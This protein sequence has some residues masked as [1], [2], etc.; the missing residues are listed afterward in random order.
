M[1]L[2]AVVAD[3]GRITR[4][5][6]EQCTSQEQFERFMQG[7]ETLQ[8]IAMSGPVKTIKKDRIFI[9]VPRYGPV[10]WE[11]ACAVLNYV[12]QGVQHDITY[13]SVSSSL[14]ANCFNRL[15]CSCINEGCWDWFALVHSDIVP[16]VEYWM[17]VMR[18]QAMRHGCWLLHGVSPIK[19]HRGV[20]STAL[21]N[22]HDEWGYVRRVTVKQ[23]FLLPETW[24]CTDYLN[25]FG[26]PVPDNPC[27]LPNTGCLLMKA[28]D[29]LR[30]F[31]IDRGFTIKDRIV[32]A[33]NGQLISWCVPEDWGTGYWCAQNGIQPWATRALNI[34]H[35]GEMDFVMTAPWGQWDEDLQYLGNI[36]KGPEAMA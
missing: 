3:L 7:V 23:T 14:L 35:K 33:A 8:G 29:A 22:A 36:G 21:G 5:F 10:A 26:G 20:T 16:S 31:A 6:Q 13:R 30:Q 32:P 1:S 17:D 28:D 11:M 34:C 4:Q 18:E 19:N 9:G 25:S 24:T 15:L 12:S 2:A 27:M